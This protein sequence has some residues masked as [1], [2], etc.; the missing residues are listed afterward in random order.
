MGISD[1]DGDLAQE[2]RPLGED[3]DVEEGLSW[4]WPAMAG[5][6]K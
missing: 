1:L 4:P 6:V 3:D 5:R 2:Q